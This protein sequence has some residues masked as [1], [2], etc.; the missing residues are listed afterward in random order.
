MIKLNKLF[1][2]FALVLALGVGAL[3][4]ASLTQTT[5]AAAQG[6]GPAALASGLSTSLSTTVSLAS[7][8][9]ITQAVNGQPV[10]FVYVD[11]EAEG[12]LTTLVGQTT[13]F[14]VLRGQLG[15]KES[16]HVTGAM[17]LAQVVSPQFG[18]N[19]GSGG[20]QATDPPVNGACLAANTNVTPWVNM[21]TEAQWLCSTI[22]STWV[23]GFN[24][25]L[26]L[27]GQ[28]Q[29]TAAVANAATFTPSG[30]LFHLTGAG[31]FVTITPPLGFSRGCVVIIM[32]AADTW[33]AAGNII[34]ASAAAQAVGE[35]VTMCWDPS[36]SKWYPSHV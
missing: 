5:L 28:S 32:D 27:G 13:I 26:N 6:A 1:S 18:G 3:G 12:I 21:I 9:G 31:A 11:Q 20:L 30:P 4:Q 17:V 10:T 16:A 35:T 23:P 14:N 34:V 7:A 33:T 8:T 24:N 15:T 25:P 2:L 22:T 29:P 19:Q 36:T